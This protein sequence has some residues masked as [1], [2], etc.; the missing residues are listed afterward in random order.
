MSGDNKINICL[1]EKFKNKYNEKV[2]N[3]RYIVSKL[4]DITCFRIKQELV[5]KSHDDKSNSLKKVIFWNI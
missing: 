2:V 4:I 5:F 1:S 3:N